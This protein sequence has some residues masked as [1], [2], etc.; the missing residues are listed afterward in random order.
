MKGESMSPRREFRRWTRRREHRGESN[1]VKSFSVHPRGRE[2][3]FCHNESQEN[4]DVLWSDED[5][6]RFSRLSASLKRLFFLSFLVI[7]ADVV[8][9]LACTPDE[10]FS[11]PF[12]FLEHID[13]MKRP[14]KIFGM[15]Q[16]LWR[17][18]D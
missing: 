15:R 5:L 11:K 16:K 10:M 2:I 7:K 1:R 13:V 14:D 3:M 17:V 6:P 9:V 8:K 4:I 12:G 18:I